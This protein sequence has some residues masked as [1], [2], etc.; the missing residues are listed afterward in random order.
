MKEYAMSRV[1]L[2]F[3]AG[4]GSTALVIAASSFA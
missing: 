3:L 2:L 1:L 4:F